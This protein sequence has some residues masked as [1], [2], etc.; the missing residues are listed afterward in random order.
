[1]D[2]IEHC[3]VP[4]HH[5]LSCEKRAVLPYIISRKTLH[6][7]VGYHV[8]VYWAV[9]EGGSARSSYVFFRL[10]AATRDS[11]VSLAFL[12]SGFLGSSKFQ[13][14]CNVPLCIHTAKSYIVE[15]Q[16]DSRSTTMTAFPQITH[17][18]F[19]MDGLLSEP[20]LLPLLPPSGPIAGKRAAR[21]LRSTVS[22]HLS[23]DASASEGSC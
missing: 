20:P 22:R 14:H 21:T 11:R 19:D 15:A 8:L 17:A 16:P 9:L 13:V 4:C 6:R 12:L 18:L 23:E 5:G 1:M 2:R 10:Y 3:T 7:R